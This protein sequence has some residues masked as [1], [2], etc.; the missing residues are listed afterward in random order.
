[1]ET[2]RLKIPYISNSFYLERPMNR[3]WTPSRILKF[4]DSLIKNNPNK[5]IFIRTNRMIQVYK[6]TSLKDFVHCD[7]FVLDFYSDTYDYKTHLA[8]TKEL[9]KQ[10]EIINNFPREITFIDTERTNNP[11]ITSDGNN[12]LY[13]IDSDPTYTSAM[14]YGEWLKRDD[15]YPLQ[16]MQFEDTE[17]YI[18][19]NPIKFLEHRYGNWEKLPKF[20]GELQHQKYI[21][22]YNKRQSK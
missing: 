8:Y 15:L 18:P 7:F 6:G 9:K 17:F 14:N 4:E 16:K 13:G 3:Y 11:N 22:E 10:L 20:I 1:M 21:D 2:V 5:L 19:Q 12:L